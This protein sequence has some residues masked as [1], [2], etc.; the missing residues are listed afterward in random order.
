VYRKWCVFTMATPAGPCHS[1]HSLY[2]MTDSLANVYTGL[3]STK[4]Y[5]AI[6]FILVQSKCVAFSGSMD[7]GCYYSSV[8]PS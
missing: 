1:T 5:C 6:T 4:L 2:L 3:L 7:E 8:A